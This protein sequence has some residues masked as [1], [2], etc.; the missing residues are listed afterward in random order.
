M[1][2][3]HPALPALLLIYFL[4]PL[5]AGAARCSLLLPRPNSPQPATN[6]DFLEHLLSK[7]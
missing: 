1:A 3:P 6:E 5:D 4:T 7:K 2:A